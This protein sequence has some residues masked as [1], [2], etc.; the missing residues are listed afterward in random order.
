G[1]SVVLEDGTFVTTVGTSTARTGIRVLDAHGHEIATSD[2]C[3]SVHG[4]G[5]AAD[6]TVIFGCENGALV[7]GDGQITKIT[8]P[9][10]YGRI[11]NAYATEESRIVLMDYKDDP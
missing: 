1:V 10:E 4:E 9:D 3:P 7:Y 6:E 11:G 2:E 5:T 8:S